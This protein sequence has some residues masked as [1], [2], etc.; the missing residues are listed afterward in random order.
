MKN[1]QIRV[2]PTLRVESGPKRIEAVA[3]KELLDDAVTAHH[4]HVGGKD[5]MGKTIVIGE[6]MTY[7]DYY[8]EETWYLYQLED[9]ELDADM[10]GRMCVELSKR[11]GKQ[12]VVSLDGSAV[13]FDVVVLTAEDI[14]EWF[15]VSTAW[16]TAAPWRMKRFM[17]R[18]ERATKEEAI[19]AIKKIGGV[20]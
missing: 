6:P 8:G 15:G 10:L 11:R 18:G 19:A 5:A 7:L 17:P 16:V 9:V 1:E 2:T 4:Y 12:T 3:T 20:E 13:V 14:A